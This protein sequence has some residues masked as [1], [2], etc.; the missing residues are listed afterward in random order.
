MAIKPY[1][2]ETGIHIPQ[3]QEIVDG[4]KEA[5][6]GIFGEDIYLEPDSQE[7]EMLELFALNINDV[8][9]FCAAVY[10]A[11]SPQTAQG[12]G[13]S[14]MSK[15][16]GIRRRPATRSYADVRLIGVAG[17]E[18]TGGIAEDTAG[19]K[20]NLPPS[21]T[22]PYE[23]EITV[24]AT[25]QDFGSV[26]AQPGEINKIATP[27][28]GWQSVENLDAAIT[29][30]AA[31]TDA[32]LRIRQT[33]STALAAQT[34][35][36]AITGNVANLSGVVQVRPYENDTD[37]TDENGLPPHSFSLVVDGG[38]IQ[39]IAQAI[40]DSKGPGPLAYGDVITPIADSTGLVTSMG[41][42]RPSVVD[43]TVSLTI[44]RLAGYSDEI[45]E[46][47]KDN[48]VSYITSLGIGNSVIL[49]KLYAPIDIADYGISTSD[50]IVS[51]QHASRFEVMDLSIARSG[52]TPAAQSIMI[53]FKEMAVLEREDIAITF[54]T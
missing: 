30:R 32:E 17:T 25:A 6:R 3:Y 10:Q 7:G 8:N 48:L 21:V 1:I 29:G 54:I 53:D 11:F 41:F 20:W 40:H 49:S 9:Q 2:D 28:R 52:D 50:Q 44:K 18:I 42:F 26:R 34:I 22:I 24:T 47:I 12:V 16:N 45:T 46:R 13:L 14:R 43:I 23:G 33:Y 37:L 4:L 36:E 15:L 39:E 19:Q 38:D 5:W 27:T 35:L 51:P 31:E